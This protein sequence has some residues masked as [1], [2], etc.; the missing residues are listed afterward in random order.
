MNT[1]Y[2]H[3]GGQKESSLGGPTHKKIKNIKN[4][5]GTTVFNQNEIIN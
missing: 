3:A 4:K 5:L 1:V 2:K